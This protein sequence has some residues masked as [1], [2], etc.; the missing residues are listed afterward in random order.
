MQDFKFI[1]S[2]F[3][4]IK[5]GDIIPIILK[6]LNRKKRDLKDLTVVGNSICELDLSKM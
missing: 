3:R 2:K 4:N 5:R 6:N 1:G